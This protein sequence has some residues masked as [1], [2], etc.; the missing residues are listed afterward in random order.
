MRVL[1][2]YGSET[3]NVRRGIHECV[4]GWQANCDGSYEL[5]TA[6]VMSGNEVAKEFSSLAELA[7]Q[8]DVLIAATSSF[9]EGD[10]PAN[11]RHFLLM[12]VRAVEA[13][14]KKPERVAPLAGLQHGVLGYGQSVYPT[15]MS[16]PRY[17]DKLLQ[18]LGSRRMVQR[19]ECDEGPEDTIKAGTETDE[20]FAMGSGPGRLVKGVV[21]RSVPREQFATAMQAALLKASTTASLPPPCDWT[22]PAAELT[23]KTVF[24]L[25]VARPLTVPDEG[26][27]QWFK[28]LFI[29]ML[30]SG[31]TYWMPQLI[32]FA[33]GA[34]L[35][36]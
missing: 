30:A 16:C 1:V 8:Y 11:F 18:T 17:T 25:L 28:Y 10:P 4:K 6:S 35:L 34:G 19:V 26:F 7:Q 15:F 12:L 2:V 9:G 14:K 22:V 24:D 27:P 13:G 33:Q 20:G 23:E 3:G 29:A 31:L 5:S 32:K 21:G 36:Q